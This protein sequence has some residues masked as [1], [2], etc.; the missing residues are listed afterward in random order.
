MA[1]KMIDAKTFLQTDK[2]TNSFVITPDYK[3]ATLDQSHHTLLS[4]HE[5]L[6]TLDDLL[7]RLGFV[8]RELKH[9]AKQYRIK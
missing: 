1:V 6:N 8:N 2:R 7:G 3:K 4:I 9:A 5:N